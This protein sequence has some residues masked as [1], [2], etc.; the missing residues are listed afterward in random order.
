MVFNLIGH[1]GNAYQNLNEI[2]FTHTRM[3]IIIIKKE[4]SVGKDVER[5]KPSYIAGGNAN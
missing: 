3:S 4:I 1:S 5:Y 2:Y